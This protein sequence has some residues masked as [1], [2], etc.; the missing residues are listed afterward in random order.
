MSCGYVKLNSSRLVLR[1]LSDPLLRRRVW[2]AEDAA[3]RQLSTNVRVNTL[4]LP[5][6]LRKVI[7]PPNN[8]A[9]F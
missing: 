7:S 3:I 2:L 4:P 8:P 1:Q 9:N 6:S 5:H